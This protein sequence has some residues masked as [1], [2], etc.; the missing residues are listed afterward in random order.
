MSIY[1]NG[2]ALSGVTAGQI[3]GLIE[4]TAAA[5]NPVTLA[6]FVV[7]RPYNEWMGRDLEVKGFEKGVFLETEYHLDEQQLMRLSQKTKGV[8]SLLYYQNMGGYGCGYY[9]NGKKVLE[10]LT[11][12]GRDMKDED[13]GQEFTGLATKRIIEQ[14]FFLLTGAT[15]AGAVKT[16]GTMYE[17]K[18]TTI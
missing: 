1:T 11:A 18:T 5:D 4:R 9:L 10:R 14:L 6:D 7:G 2:Y 3:A 13:A 15:L 12:V 16:K 8:L 17:F